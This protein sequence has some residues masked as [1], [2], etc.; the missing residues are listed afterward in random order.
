[1]NCSSLIEKRN[2]LNFTIKWISVSQSDHQPPTVQIDLTLSWLPK[3][4]LG[5][6]S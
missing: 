5:P 6:V 1:M 4:F 2:I 3:P